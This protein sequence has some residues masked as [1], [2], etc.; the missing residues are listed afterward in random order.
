LKLSETNFSSFFSYDDSILA[1]WGV[2]WPLRFVHWTSGL[3][4]LK[5]ICTEFS[6]VSKRPEKQELR[7]VVVQN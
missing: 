7:F 1:P 4:T 6:K 3:L 5:E 2:K